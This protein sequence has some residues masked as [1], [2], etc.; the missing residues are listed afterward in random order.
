MARR[1]I[2]IRV[3]YEGSEFC[4]WQRQTGQPSVQEALENALTAVTGESEAITGASRTD[5]GVHALGQIATFRT[6]SRIA[7]SQLAQALT[8]NLPESICVRKSETVPDIFHP[9]KDAIL[10]RYEYRFRSDFLRSPLLDR[11]WTHLAYKVDVTPMHDAAQRLIGTHDFRGFASK[12][13]NYG[14]EFDFQRT[15]S[16]I[17]LIRPNWDDPFGVGGFQVDTGK[18][19]DDNRGWAGAWILRIEGDGFLHNMIR[20]IM[21]SLFLVGR[22]KEP[23][24]YLDEILQNGNRREAGPTAPPQGLCLMHVFYPPQFGDL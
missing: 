19:T 7:S 23:P 1:L 18:L 16:K 9:R 11:F 2:R 8:Y 3:E 5:S 6:E 13:G 14:D 17:D 12:V 15:I 4:G 10:K 22:G 20:A 21:G 24:E